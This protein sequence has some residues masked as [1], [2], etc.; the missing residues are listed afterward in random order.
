MT[1]RVLLMTPVTGTGRGAR[2]GDDEAPDDAALRSA[3]AVAARLPGRTRAYAAPGACCRATA[4]ALGVHAVPAR[5]LADL[6]TG[7]WRGRE[8]DEVAAA[9]P[10]ALAA[11]LSDPAAAPHGGESVLALA[12]RTTRWLAA[13]AGAGGR[14]LAVVPQAVVRAAVVGALELPPAVFWRLDVPPLSATELTGR[15]GRWNW[16]CARLPED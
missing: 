7:R 10:A 3:R 4:G 5:E 8:P 12:A 13:Q 14:V 11:W 6:D 15:A 2:F 9:E 16:R 1:V